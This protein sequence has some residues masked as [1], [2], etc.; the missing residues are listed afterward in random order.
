MTVKIKRQGSTAARRSVLSWRNQLRGTELLSTIFMTTLY[1]SF[2]SLAESLI[3][4][5]S[6]LEWGLELTE[7]PNTSG[8][9]WSPT[10]I[11]FTLTK[12][13]EW[14]KMQQA[15][16]KHKH[17]F[18]AGPLLFYFESG[19]FDKNIA[20]WSQLASKIHWSL[21]TKVLPQPEASSFLKVLNSPDEIATVPNNAIKQV[22]GNLFLY[23]MMCFCTANGVF[24]QV[25]IG[26][27][28]S[29]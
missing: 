29:G 1:L 8:P 26:Q 3:F 16:N 12:S 25:L 21:S 17:L 20:L 7:A 18:F 27:T 5:Y 13:K 4:F 24:K 11:L 6:C 28:A 15:S 2:L 22:T 23:L 10:F 9:V 14:L 19:S